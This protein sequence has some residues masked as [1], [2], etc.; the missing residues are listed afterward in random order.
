[1]AV[2]SRRARFFVR[3]LA[4]YA[5]LKPFIHASRES[6]LGK[7]MAQRPETIGA[8]VWPYQCAAWDAETRL[9][10]IREHFS[11]IEQMGAP[12]DFSPDGEFHVLDLTE[13]KSG[14]RVVVDQPRWFLREGQLAINLFVDE[15]RMYTLAF[16]L[17]RDDDGAIAAFI[18]SLQGRDIDGVV[19]DYRELTKASHGIHPRNLLVKI[20]QMF[21]KEIGI[22]RILAVADAF[23]VHRDRGYF[24][25]ASIKKLH[26]NYDEIWVERG[27][28][29][30]DPT[31]FEIEVGDTDTRDLGE[32]TSTKRKKYR[33]R[34]ALLGS[35]SNQLRE[36]FGG[37]T[38]LSKNDVAVCEP[39]S[40]PTSKNPCS[41]G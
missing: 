39:A 28:K 23:R 34:Y 33:K 38:A 41:R 16:S 8:A 11:V 35:I 22:A 10:R 2:A 12:I 21:C 1:L 24:G 30:I 25:E 13:I 20:F 17:F 6:L 9:L 37:A 5:T 26:A 31:C 15:T 19:E 27:G 40:C 29:Q 4:V 7:L 18:G 14:L 32:M 36:R 3:S